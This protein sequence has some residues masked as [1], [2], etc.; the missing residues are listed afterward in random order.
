VSGVAEKSTDAIRLLPGVKRFDDSTT[1][2]C[3]I[4]DVMLREL[5]DIREFK[6][7]DQP[8]LELGRDKDF[9][10]GLGWL[11]NVKLEKL[12]FTRPGVIQI[13]AE[14]DGL[15]IDA[16]DVRFPP[17][18][19]FKLVEIGPMSQTYRPGPDPAKWVEIFSP[20]HDVTV[21]GF[22]LSGVSVQG[23]KMSDADA[24]ARFVQVKDQAVNPEYPLSTPRGGTGKAKLV[25]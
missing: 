19:D 9:S 23:A 8:N 4:S 16:V 14:V 21:R 5:T 6:F 3:S 25:R 17:G 10:V 13:A 12:V 1:L 2:D 22:R 7:Y 20:D 11:R 15:S 24:E 18:D